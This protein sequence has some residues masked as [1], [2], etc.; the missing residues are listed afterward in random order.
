LSSNNHAHGSNHLIWD[1][2]SYHTA[3]TANSDST[4]SNFFK[5]SWQPTF[6][7]CAVYLVHP[8]GAII[9]TNTESAGDGAGT[10]AAIGTFTSGRQLKNDY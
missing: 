3:I 8:D 10:S 6:C 9:C 7:C 4:A 1:G 5:I 2:H